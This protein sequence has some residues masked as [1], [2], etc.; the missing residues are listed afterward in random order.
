MAD[1]H[2]HS[3]TQKAHAA[4]GSDMGAAFAGLVI[5]ALS[6]FLLLGA[7]VTLTNRYY[8]SEKP[9]KAAER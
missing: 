1:T 6:L 5:G 7:I 3:P 9:T 4:H 8:A 2:P